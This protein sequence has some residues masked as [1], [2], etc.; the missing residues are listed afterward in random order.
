MLHYFLYIILS[1]ILSFFLIIPVGIAA[2]TMSNVSQILSITDIHFDPYISCRAKI[3]CPLIQKLQAAPVEKW[4]TILT[5]DD[6]EEPHYKQ[7]TTYILWRHSLAMAKKLEVQ[8]HP[9]FIVL[10]GDLL[11]HEF[12]LKYVKY[13]TD[14][15]MRNYKKFLYKNLQFITLQLT[16]VFPQTDVYPVVGNN[17]TYDGDYKTIPKGA[18]FSDVSK[19]WSGLIKDAQ[20]RSL[21]QKEFSQAGYYS[22]VI[23]GQSQLRL[24]V[25]NTNL[26]SNKVT[27]KSMDAAAKQEL[28]WLR[29]TL[30][31]AKVSHQKVFIAM[32][33]PL[34][35][36]VYASLR[37]R[38]FTVLQLWHEHFARRFEKIL[39]QNAD[40]ITAIFAAHLHSDWFQIL[41]LNKKI[42]IPISGSP[43]ISPIFNNNPGLKVFTY[44]TLNDQLIGFT[45]Y[46]YPLQEL[47]KWSVKTNFSRIYEENCETCPAINNH[48]PLPLYEWQ[49]FYWCAIHKQ[50]IKNSAACR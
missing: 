5:A 18:F 38:L 27:A 43:A 36:D 24:V 30:A 3:P 46:Y 9:K 45:T 28:N 14:K 15:K 10:L 29:E 19:L 1:A 47:K 21:M 20:N 48:E 25:L 6:H 16:Q 42:E 33:I 31:L 41:T 4:D 12:D 49:P 17:D 11:P 39:N 26:F 40:I 13:T 34:G 2:P 7:D 32:H 37:Y 44:S 22:V 50:D 23:P 35:I 8:N